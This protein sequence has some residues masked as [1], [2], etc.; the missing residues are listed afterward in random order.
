MTE[1]PTHNDLWSRH[2]DSI[3]IVMGG[4]LGGYLGLSISQKG[5]LGG[6]YFNLFALITLSSWSV[7]QIL[8]A[9][10][11][12]VEGVKWLSFVYVVSL[13]PSVILA[14]ACA[15][16]IGIDGGIV[17]TIFV[18]WASM[19]ISMITALEFAKWLK[20]FENV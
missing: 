5:V 1:L 12:Y 2:R 18:S 13:V 6:S 16:R 3:N 20:R 10:N 4:I 19:I 9:Y 8:E 11:R 7:I 17:T 15:N 14:S